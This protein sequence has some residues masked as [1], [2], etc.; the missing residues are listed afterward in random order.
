M[1]VALGVIM[2]VTTTLVAVVTA[3]VTV[4]AIRVIVVL[5][6]VGLV[7]NFHWFYNGFTRKIVFLT[8]VEVKPLLFYFT[9][10]FTMHTEQITVE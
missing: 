3:R 4:I 6:F 1:I 8:L 2:I 7:V 9:V 5:A 10:I